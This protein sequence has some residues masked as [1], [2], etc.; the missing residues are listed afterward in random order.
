[1]DTTTVTIRIPSNILKAIRILAEVDTRT[2]NAQIVHLLKLALQNDK[3]A[4]S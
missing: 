1:M 3:P 4:R 2:L